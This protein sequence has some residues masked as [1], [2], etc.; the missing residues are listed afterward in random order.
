MIFG[1]SITTFTVV[2]VVISLIGIFSGIAVVYGMITRKRLERW[3]A[4]FLTTT[5]LTSITGFFFP[6]KELLPSHIFGFISLAVLAIVIP[7]LYIYRLAGA[8]RWIYIAGAVLVLY[9]NTFVA[10]VQ[11]FLKIPALKPLAPTQSE[12][13][14]LLAQLVVMA[15]FIAFGVV[16]VRSFHPEIKAAR[17]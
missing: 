16:A 3:T 7:A 2:H 14:F 11:A 8:W 1:M 12:P 17:S 9:L 13:P 6:F 15:L 10:V 4:L 5:V